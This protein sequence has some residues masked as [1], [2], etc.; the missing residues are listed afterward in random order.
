MVVY[1]IIKN[2]EIM[3]IGETAGFS[4]MCLS[5][6]DGGYI[7]VGMNGE[8]EGIEFVIKCNQ[9]IKISNKS[10]IDFIIINYGVFETECT[11]RTKECWL[12]NSIN[13]VGLST[14]VAFENGVYEEF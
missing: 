10:K 9:D 3:K 6:V 5:A 11:K 8:A 12:I 2:G 7:F 4:A 14:T 13:P 1:F